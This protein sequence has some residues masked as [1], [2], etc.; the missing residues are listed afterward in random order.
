MW[1]IANNF[2]YENLEKSLLR[3]KVAEENSTPKNIYEIYI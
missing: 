1:K 3:L 2:L